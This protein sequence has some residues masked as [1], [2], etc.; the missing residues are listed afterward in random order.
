[1]A[2]LLQRLPPHRRPPHRRPVRY[3]EGGSVALGQ[4]TQKLCAH[5]RCALG[6]LKS[7]Q[8]YAHTL[9][10]ALHA[11]SRLAHQMCFVRLLLVVRLLFQL[12]LFF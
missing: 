10:L 1:M 4:S 3:S 9:A 6:A 2:R 5:F 7:L 11:S 12:R 8:A